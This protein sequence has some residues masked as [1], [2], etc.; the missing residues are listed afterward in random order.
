MT[1][2]KNLQPI[3]AEYSK[4]LQR[5]QDSIPQEWLE[6]MVTKQPIAPTIRLAYEKAVKDKGIAKNFYDDVIKKMKAEGIEIT[7][8]IE[9]KVMKDCKKRASE[10]Q[11]KAQIILDSGELDRQMEVVDKRYEGYV[12]KFIDKEIELAMRRGELPKG[13][14]FRNLNKKLKRIVKAKK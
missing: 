6:K 1:K 13:K 2:L 14:K 3:K 7:Q 10:L 4:V 9:K 12:N 5:I 11:R 8:E